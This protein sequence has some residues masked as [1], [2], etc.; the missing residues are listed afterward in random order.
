MRKSFYKLYTNN[1]TNL[2]KFEEILS[3]YISHHNKKCYLYFNICEFELEIVKNFTAKIEISFHFKTD[4]KNIKS[5]SLYY[6]DSCELGGFR[7]I[8]VNHMIIY[9][10]SSMCNT[11][12]EQYIIQPM[13]AIE[14]KLNNFIA[15]NPQLINSLDRNKPH[16]LIN[17]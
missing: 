6:I 7:P 11:T 15:K 1:R 13:Q 16:P 2:D 3:D 10:I 12:Y 9:T 17:R 14:L 4:T 8:K 5:Y